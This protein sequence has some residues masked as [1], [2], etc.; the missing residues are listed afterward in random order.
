[1]LSFTG[2]EQTAS[3][4]PPYKLGLALSGG[5]ARGFAHIGVI[6]A[7]EEN[8]I[9][10]DCISGSSSGALIGLFY[11]SGKSPD[12]MIEIAGSIK[13]HKLTAIR[14]FHFGKAG[15]DYVEQLLEQHV[16]QTTFEELQKPLFVC[17]T[18]FQTGRYEIIHTGK[19]LPALRAS[20]A[21]PVKFGEQVING[22]KYIDGGMTNNMPVEPLRECCRTVVGISINP[23]A[24]KGGNMKL[25]HKI[26]RLT[27][28]LLNENEVRRIG[29]C[30]Y[31]LEVAGLGEIEF[32]DYH[33]TR[34]IH[35]LGYRAAKVFIA[36]NPEL[37]TYKITS[38]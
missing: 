28:L 24:Y 32:E 23:L 5:A 25:R 11:A 27:E 2:K 19:I 29:W 9:E 7:F 20:T 38:S 6:R 16:V 26:M 13:R 14:P 15:L 4:T 22:V 31:H 18:N 8:G 33:R 10:I 30:D 12:E 35:D 36:E 3:S 17:V 1:M 34:E 21:I 37:S